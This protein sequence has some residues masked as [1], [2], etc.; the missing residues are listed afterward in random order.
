M[1]A[2]RGAAATHQEAS[3]SPGTGHGS[4]RAMAFHGAAVDGLRAHG[5][6][7]MLASLALPWPWPAGLPGGPGLLGGAG[8]PSPQ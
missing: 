2:V 6:P 8:Q 1:A 3:G 7:A 4:G 5:R